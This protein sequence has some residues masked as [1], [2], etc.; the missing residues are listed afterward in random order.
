MFLRLEYQASYLTSKDQFPLPNFRALANAKINSHVLELNL[1]PGRPSPLGS[2]SLGA[3]VMRI[4]AECPIS[5]SNA[6]NVPSHIDKAD[7]AALHEA[8]KLALHQS[9]VEIYRGHAM[10]GD[11]VLYGR[12]GLLWAILNI[13]NHIFDEET[14]TALYPIFKVVP[15]LVDAI[16]DAGKLGAQEYVKQHGEPGALPL[17]WPWFDQY[18]AVGA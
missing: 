12:A 16:M 3:A 13:R 7:I 17:M 4:V 9:H 18:Y 1:Q 11:E 10:G 5:H 15:K 2:A 8:V 6:G 14:R